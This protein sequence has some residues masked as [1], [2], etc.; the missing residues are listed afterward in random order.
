MNNNL[1]EVKGTSGIYKT[2]EFGNVYRNGK[3]L[4]TRVTKKGYVQTWL[5]VD[6]KTKYK[7]IHRIVAESFLPILSDSHEVNHKDGNKLNNH[8]SNLEWVS[9]LDNIKHAWDNELYKRGEKSPN[10]KLKDSDVVKIRELNNE[11]VSYA[12][13]GEMYNISKWS[14]RDICKYDTWKHIA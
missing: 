7:F 6:A 14:I 11:G 13:L 10:T 4:S 8:V 12:K 5:T 2:D 1:V 9:R 3:K